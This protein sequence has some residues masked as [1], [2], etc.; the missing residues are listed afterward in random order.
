M[1]KLILILAIATFISCSNDDVQ[2]NNCFTIIQKKQITE[3]PTP[4]SWI[5]VYTFDG[6]KVSKA[7]YDSYNVG[8]I[9]CPPNSPSF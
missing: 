1:K 4:N 7:I 2:T 5:L 3:H 9:Y 8:E 6:V